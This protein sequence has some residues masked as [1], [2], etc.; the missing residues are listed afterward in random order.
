VF[1]RSGSSWTQQQELVDSTADSDAYFGISVALSSDGNT[2]LIGGYGDSGGVGAAWVF[3]RSGSSWTQQ[4]ELVDS[5][6]DSNASF[7]TSVALSSDGNTALIGGYYDSGGLGAAWVFTRSGSSWT[8]QEELVDSTADNSAYF[9]YSV[10]LSSDGNTALIGGYNDSGGAGAAWVFTR[11]GSSWTQ[12]QELVDSPTDSYAYFGDSVALSSDG[13]T[14][15][16]GGDIGAGAA[17]VFTRSGSTWTQQQELVDS[18]TDSYAYFGD[19]VALSSDGNTALIGGAGDSSAVGAAWVFAAPSTTN[20]TAASSVNPSPTGAPV[21]YTATVNPAPDGGTLAFADNGVTISGCGT[22]GVDTSSGTATCHVTYTAAGSHPIT[23]GYSG[24]SNYSGSTSATLTQTVTA[25][26]AAGSTGS[27]GS[28]PSSAFTITSDTGSSIGTIT[29]GVNL[30]G[31]GRVDVLGT[32][33][34]VVGGTASALEPGYHRF[35]WGRR[36]VNATSAGDMTITL[37]PDTNG[38]KLLVRHH[39]H[40]WATNVRVWLTY[41]PTAGYPRTKE[42]NVR[43]FKAKQH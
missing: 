11:S 35:A 34:G 16:I 39:H 14:A 33:V 37:K 9:G 7:G 40:G 20:T 4:E 26:P 28:P 12:Q 31:P 21:T 38:K 15:L 19:S 1:T 2:A 27:S 25:A 32:H 24:D 5:T 42:V 22:V 3:T 17:W 13:N 43:L 23:A 30:P 29:L 6:A 10:A 36:T 18:P 41:T 8:Q